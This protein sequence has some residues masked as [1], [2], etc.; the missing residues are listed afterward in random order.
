MNE[1]PTW[2]V[3]LILPVPIR[4]LFTYRV[5]FALNDAVI[6]GQRVIVPFGKK[7]RITGIVAKIH[8]D[9]P[10]E[11][12]AK[13]L[14]YI[15]D[16]Q[17]IITLEQLAFWQWISSYYLAPIGDVMNVALPAN[18]KLAS[19]TVIVLHPDF[20]GN[21]QDASPKETLVLQLLAHREKIELNELAE[22]TDTNNVALLV[23]KMIEKGM[24][25]TQEEINQRYSPKTKTYLRLHPDLTD[26]MLAA[27]LDEL[28]RNSRT[29]GQFTALLRLKQLT[30]E[31]TLSGAYV[32]KKT[33][34][35]YDVTLSSINSLEKK[36]AIVQEKLQV[37][38]LQEAQRSLSPFPTLS[39]PQQ[40]ALNAIE[41]SWEKTPITLLHGV[42]GSGKTEIYMHLIQSFMDLGK[43]VLFL[44]P[45]IALTTQLIQRLEKYFGAQVGVYHS[46]FNQNE[47]V[48]IWQNVFANDMERYRV[49]VGAR[50]SIFLPFKDLGLVI[51]DEEHEASYK[52]QDPSPRYH[53]RDAAIYLARKCGAK[54]LLGSATPSLESYQ[55]TKE[56][57]YGLVQLNE[58]FQGVELPAFGIANLTEEKKANTMSSHFSS[59]LLEEIKRCLDNKTQVIL[60][61]NR[62][63]YTPYWNCEIC[64]WIPKCHQC[65]VSLTYHLQENLL[66]CHYCGYTASPMGSCAAC[67]SHKLKMQG[68]G[69]EKIEDELHIL[70]PEARIHRMDLDTTR[71][72]NAYSELIHHFQARNID[73]L[74]GTQMLAKG[75][76][77]DN[78]ALVGI[79][80]ADQLLNTPNFRAYERGFQ[81]LTQVS[82]R[83]G[84][85]HKRGK[86][87]IQT[88][89]P[90]HWIIQLVIENNTLSFLEQE[91][92]ERENF[93][94]PPFYKL[95]HL[96]LKHENESLLLQ[97]AL[98]LAHA[99]RS[100]LGERI[101]GPAFPIIKRLQGQYQQEIKIKYEKTLSDKRI[102][103]YLLALLDTF[104]ETTRYKK[105]RV[106]VDVDPY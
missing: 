41:I 56:G 46:K 22:I 54:V 87:V 66:K 36:G 105:I 43:Q 33:L 103:E 42:T 91:L 60:F 15:L 70:L 18:F 80:D 28:E 5:P 14:D 34:L 78:V 79:L 31:R 92:K 49:I 61:Q 1:R 69:T 106:N 88:R 85:K 67:G 76:D 21:L 94:Y 95:I 89:N 9:A 86:A 35:S 71:S 93:L 29:K 16:E 19:E 52:Q 73:I 75:L 96:N 48:E 98:D 6:I 27:L 24:I 104:Y 12:T 2:Y 59:F 81:L 20:D 72:K 74:I 45:E 62:R 3:D 100:K 58:R 101:I 57:K 53:G 97:G 10:G 11:Y 68:F 32:E 83:A 47:R 4:K 23:K 64:G 38:R 40:T 82:G 77:F 51:V 99:L 25:I 55:N 90:N 8:E 26:H 50:S 30:D 13:F 17:P 63:G 84:R 102:K 7:K 39:H 65:D 37:D 44:I